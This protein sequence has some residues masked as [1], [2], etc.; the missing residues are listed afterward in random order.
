ML[1]DSEKKMLDGEK[2]LPGVMDYIS[3]ILSVKIPNKK[4]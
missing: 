4:R 3:R 2:K 1:G